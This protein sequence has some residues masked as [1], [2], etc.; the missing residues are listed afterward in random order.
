M[1]RIKKKTLVLLGLVS[2]LMVFVSACIGSV[3]QSPQQ[4]QVIYPTVV[5]TQ[6]VTQV[7]A[8]PT[9]A[10]TVAPKPVVQA[11]AP[12]TTGGWDPM[13]VPI[14]YPLRGCVASRIHEGDVAFV[15]NNAGGLGIHYSKDVHYS[16]IFRNLE[17]GELIDIVKGP[18][19]NEGTIIWKAATDEGYIGFVAEGN[20]SVY[21][22]LPMGPE[23]ES[24]LT[25]E[26]LKLREVVPPGETLNFMNPK[27]LY[28][29]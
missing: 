5:I 4:P 17:S 14:Y 7:V 3:A 25:K 28:C 20:G 21:W 16:P 26:E 11:A 24:V 1:N 23:T 13:S 19:C 29:R 2:S 9:T 22:L 10:P 27:Q 12:V 18:W 8:T 6:F 15:A